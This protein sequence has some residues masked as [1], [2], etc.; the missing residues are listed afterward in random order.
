MV[1]RTVGHKQG[2]LVERKHSVKAI[3]AVYLLGLLLGGLYVGMVAPVRLVIQEQFGLS[4]ATGIWM[5]NIYTLFYAACIPVIGKLADVRGRKPVFLGCLTV[6]AAGSLV[7][8]L[9]QMAGGFTMLLTGRLAQAVGACGVIPVANAE[10][11]ATFPQEKK[12]MALGI[13]AAVA[14]IANVLGAAL[15]SLVVG[16]VGNEHWSALFF[17]AIPVC[18]ALVIAGVRV[19][20]NRK[21]DAGDTLDV[22]GSVLLVGT[23]LL[24]LF[25]LQNVDVSNLAASLVSR[26]VAA[27]AVGFAVFLGAFVLVERRAESPVFHLEYLGNRPIVITMVVSFFVGCMTITMSLIPEVAEFVMSAPVGSGGLYILPVGV[28]C[29][30]GPP[31][32]GKLIDK[33]GPKPVLMSGLGIA[34]VGFLF[35]AF[36]SLNCA[37]AVLLIVGLSIMGLGMGFA[38]GAPTNYMILENTNP[39]ESGSAIA[40]IAL[41]RQVGT[42]VAPAVL[43][44][45]VTA[46]PG[47]AGFFQMLVCAAGF[48]LVSLAVMVLYR[49]R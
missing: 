9:S 27:P 1:G 18:A 19:L 44:G 40:T 42:T 41:V 35:L 17:F 34:A 29:M 12:G 2:L 3:F 33:F 14:G 25:A 31:L 26:D 20:P 37:N 13:A 43:L 10:I 7:C 48:C 24:L 16:L 11:G 22:P 28:M 21:N 5:I 23:V 8:G 30:F 46:H 47:A 39:A 49:K 4:D 32:G 45:F 15:G 36:V 38:M 6:F